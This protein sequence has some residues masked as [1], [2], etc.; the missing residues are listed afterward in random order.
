MGNLDGD[1]APVADPGG[2]PQPSAGLWHVLHTRSRQEKALADDL[3][4]RR[5]PHFLPLVRQVR[6]YGKRKFFAEMPLF[7]GYVFL[8]GELD[9][10]YLA[11]RTKR[12]AAIIKVADQ[13]RIDWELRNIYLALS[14]NAPL[15]PYPHLRKGIRVEVRSG[16]FRGLQ[17]IIEDRV[18]H[19]RLILQV[20]MLG[21]AVSLEIH[22]ALVEPV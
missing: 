1:T 20:D 5:I 10:A 7:P 12:V 3:S 16:P 9:D 21:V 15:D 22:G 19:D 13:Q 8:R 2:F 18:K 11:D 14:T 4:A 6:Y 17:G